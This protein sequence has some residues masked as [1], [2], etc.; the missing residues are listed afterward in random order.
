MSVKDI[1]EHF[2]QS[3]LEK[4]MD[5][6]IELWDDEVPSHANSASAIVGSGV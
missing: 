1:M 4:D 6:W 5:R 3:M 2:V